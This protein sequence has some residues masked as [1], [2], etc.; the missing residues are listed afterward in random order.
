MRAVA[1]CVSL[2]ATMPAT[3]ATTLEAEPLPGAG[4]YERPVDYAAYAAP[5][6]ARTP[7]P[8]EG[9]LVIRPRPGDA[10]VAVLRDDYGDA[11]DPDRRI[12]ELPVMDV[13]FVLVGDSLVPVVAGLVRTP[14]PRWDYLVG[15]GRAWRSADD[16]GYSRAA[17]PFALAE[18]NANCVHNGVL[19][20][21]YRPDGHVSR[22][23]YQVSGETCMYLKADFWGYAD[24]E[25]RPGDV[26]GRADAIR[27]WR[28]AAD[29]AVPRRSIAELARRYPGVD[30]GAYA[31]PNDVREVSTFGVVV[32]GTFYS[33]GC[34][35]RAGEY[36]F[37]GQLV[38]PSYSL[39]KSVFA[40][41][42]LMRLEHLRPGAARETVAAHVPECRASGRWDDVTLLDL[43][44]MASGNFVSAAP[45]ADEASADLDRG[46]FLATTHVEKVAHACNGYPR[47]AP[48]G[49][50]F[51]YRTS[52]TYLLGV[53]MTDE[54]RALR[55][56]GADLVGDLAWPGIWH[57]MGLP[58]RV[59]GVRR[60]EDARAQPF[61][62]YGLYLEPGDV[63]RIAWRLD[64]DATLPGLDER[65]YREA[66]QR[67]PARRGRPVAGPPTCCTSTD[68]GPTVPRGCP[69]ATGRSTYRFCPA[70]AA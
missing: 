33:G 8:F 19:S 13:A 41:L 28:A 65:L 70:T 15:E 51:V 22:V 46:F 14:H 4:R 44:D 39:A 10:H 50:Q 34:P 17:I 62:G 52:D 68:S 16:R 7:E 40:A 66:L 25:Y 12:A 59:A 67:D 35:T 9:R 20:F 45:M 56:P 2:L 29:R 60:T 48:P 47:G 23:A 26:E 54:L 30:A 61:V 49:T 5:A 21:L 36:P 58:S 53:A 11:R 37:C 43:L 38:L 31:D 57:G 64:Q 55:G 24:A 32:D 18:K 3:G 63:A 69:A 1:L 42:A 6:A 27:E